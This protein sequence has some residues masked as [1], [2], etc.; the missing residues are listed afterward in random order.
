MKFVSKVRL[1]CPC[2]ALLFCLVVLITTMH[3]RSAVTTTTSL[4]LTSGSN[5][6]T[7][8]SAGNTV[9]LTATV[10]AGTSAVTVG[11]VNF[12]DATAAGCTDIHLLGTA[13]L[14]AAGTASIKLLPSIGSHSYKAVF[15]GTLHGTLITTGSTS[16]TATLTVTGIWPS[17]TNLS[18]S[19][20][21]GNYTLTATS[22]GSGNAAPTGSISFVDTSKNTAVLDS[23]PL[24]ADTAGLNFL[25]SPSFPP[26]PN[27]SAILSFPS[28]AAG[29]FNGDGV[30]DIA[31]AT[32]APVALVTFL[33]DGHGNFPLAVNS[34][35]SKLPSDLTLYVI[36]TG[37]FNGD[38]FADLLVGDSSSQTITVLLGDGT[39]AFKPAASTAIGG[40]FE[41]I[42]IADFNGDGIPDVAVANTTANLITLFLGKGDGTFTAASTPP[43]ASSNNTIASGDFNG[44]GIPDLV[45]VN[46]GI[47][48]S[49]TATILLGNGDG[50]FTQVSSGPPTGGFPTSMA[51]GDFNG[52]GKTD[53]AFFSEFTLTVLLG[54]GDG[55]FTALAPITILIYP[56]SFSMVGDFNGDGK[57]DLAVHNRGFAGTSY[58]VDI[59]LGDG[60][61]GFLTGFFASLLPSAAI[62]FNGDGYTDL[63]GY[64]PSEVGAPQA[65]GAA[66]AVTQTANATIQGLVVPVASGNHLV[67]ASYGGDSEYGSNTSGTVTL[68]AVPGTPTVA[69]A[70]SASQVFSGTQVTLTATVTGSG[71]TPTGSMLFYDGSGLLGQSM[72]NSSGVGTYT[73]TSLVVGNNNI[74]ASYQGDSNYNTANSATIVVVVAA[75]GTNTPTMMLT[76]SATNVTDQQNVTV[77]VSV[78]G[79]S[80]QATPTGVLA[81]AAGTYNT[82]QTLA[83]GMANVNIPAGTLSSGSNTIS[84]TYLG[85]ANYKSIS[86]TT[87][88][89]VSPVLMTASA[90]APVTPGSM[91]TATVSL[92]AG[93]TYSGTIKLACS[94]TNSPSGAQ[95]LHTCSLNPASLAIAASGTGTATLTMKTTAAT[96]TAM[97]QPS[98][99]GLWGVGGSALACLIMLGV[100]S[101]RRWMSMLGLLL[102]VFAVGATG[103]GG[104]SG[105][106][107]P[108]NPG[109]TAGNYTFTVTG[110]DSTNS[111]ITAST[112]VT[113]TVQ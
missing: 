77:A 2:Q 47:N 20:N 54:I 12:C 16:A 107:T 45:G 87:T 82:Q 53:L 90:P 24:V 37:D 18:V 62:D 46:T 76:P 42:A 50:T 35:L 75:P 79:A 44:D 57:P 38:G 91:G 17:L 51:L 8:L 48:G 5:P 112:A 63:A 32:S 98:R 55:T 49:S 40:A 27:Q 56:G 109:T 71:L 101:R 21:P 3:A 97:A 70:S 111:S 64:F 67:E 103:C 99:L 93:S 1:I 66:I 78:A 104:G 58:G 68:T 102:I 86:Q 61:G 100:P 96:N 52:D 89:T 94:L 83:N 59:L 80:G 84:V 106:K 10:S 30:P 95:S 14:T 88:V 25:Y 110:T 29:D 15:A 36:G 105:S 74:T 108:S 33:G 23:A 9:T 31:Q 60:T 81:L 73:T 69:V 26:P 92:S 65:V 7:T 11:Q 72:L 39:G 13:Q 43:V 6:V 85:D 4:A 34:D 113:L 22:G 28:L 19:G 41:S